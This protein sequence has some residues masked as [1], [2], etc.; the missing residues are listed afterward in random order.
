MG[1]LGATL[2]TAVALGV[3][4]LTTLA[5]LLDGTGLFLTLLRSFAANG[6]DLE[7]PIRAYLP[8]A[9]QLVTVTVAFTILIGLVNLIGVH[10]TRLVRRPLSGFGSLLV[11]V[12]GVG[13]LILVILERTNVL[14]VTPSYSTFL[15]QN[16]QYSVEASLAGLLAFSL[17][18]GVYRLLRQRYTVQSIVFVA[19]LV[20]TLFIQ[21]G[22]GQ[23]LPSVVLNVR[24]WIVDAGADGL[25]LGVGLAT[26][27]AG[28]RVLIGQDRSY[29]E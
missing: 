5:L 24:Q 15:R 18:F 2:A 26:L 7:A 6:I 3:G 14:T 23:L 19:A 13:V 12:S 20:L 10:I 9:L 22:L 29:R 11:V 8:V 28:I 21:A 25:V 4:F 1:R 16:V 17:I 27:V